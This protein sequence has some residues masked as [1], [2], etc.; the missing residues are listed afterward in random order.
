MTETVRKDKAEGLVNRLNFVAP[1]KSM[2]L[3]EG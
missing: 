3:N 2:Q 1:R